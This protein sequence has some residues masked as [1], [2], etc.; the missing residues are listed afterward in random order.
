L[1]Q[2]IKGINFRKAFPYLVVL[3]LF[4]LALNIRWRTLYDFCFLFTDSDQLV[5]WCAAN[6]MHHGIFHEPCFYGQ[7]YSPLFEPLFVQPFIWMGLPFQIDLPLVSGI[8]GL[9]PF[10]L[11][12]WFLFKRK[13][14]I[15][16][17][18]AF[19]YLLWLPVEFHVITSIPRGYI[20][21]TSF[22]AIG[23]VIALYSNNKY[24]FAWFA[25]FGALGLFTSE[26]SFFLTLPVGV[27]IWIDQFKNRKFY[28]QGILGFMAS[29]PLP[30]LIY[31]FYRAHPSY[32]LHL[33]EFTFDSDTFFETIRNTDKYFNFFTPD[34]KFK[35]VTVLAFYL[36][37]AALCF[38]RKNIKAGISILSG[39]LLFLFALSFDKSQDASDS[40]F[41]SAVR[42]FLGVPVSF[43]VFFGWIEESFSGLSSFKN[44]K[45]VA[46]SILLIIGVISSLER[47]RFFHK[48]LYVPSNIDDIIV[49]DR[50][51]HARFLC[52]QTYG[53]CKKYNCSLVIIDNRMIQVNYMMPALNY[54][55]RTMIPSYERRTWIMQAED[56]TI[57][58]NF[59]Y[60]AED[61]DKTEE[62]PSYV[63]YKKI[64]DGP[65]YLVQTD[66]RKV[67]AILNDMKVEIRKH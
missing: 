8:L 28:I 15:S 57:R 59:I 18:F 63:H 1:L 21:G 24:R 22:A 58:D 27:F 35:F 6:D 2:R 17:A 52:D 4:L 13:Y 47:N 43:I 50:V 34:Q 10:L 51:S 9:L 37:F 20:T 14:L 36:F 5:L 40:P 16:A 26:N 41:Y 53:L 31:W 12:G 48:H 25:F 19:A 33:I 61:E 54:P 55:V 32:N 64:G 60:F 45:Q 56:S 46:L 66:G 44:I 3:V 49:E 7:A 23:V 67:F 30:A 62:I 38:I 65:A 29:L 39:L 11:I 42:M